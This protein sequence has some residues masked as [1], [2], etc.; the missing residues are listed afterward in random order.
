MTK[1]L[2]IILEN[3]GSFAGYII[4][5]IGASFLLSPWLA[6]AVIAGVFLSI[7]LLSIKNYE[8]EHRRTYS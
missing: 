4:G 6:V 2:Q 7:F 3:L 8:Q 1:M 5:G